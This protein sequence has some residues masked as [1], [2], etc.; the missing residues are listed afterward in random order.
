M[1]ASGSLLVARSP[2][3]KALLAAELGQSR[4]WGVDWP[5]SARPR[6]PSRTAGYYHPAGD[7]HVVW[8]PEDVYI[9]EPG[10]LVAAYLAA[11]QRLGVQVLAGEEVT[12]VR[13]AGASHRAADAPAGS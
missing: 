9:E 11:C 8:C 1:A 4:R 13:S 5:R 3:H 6:R 7:E 10:A 12:A 2:G